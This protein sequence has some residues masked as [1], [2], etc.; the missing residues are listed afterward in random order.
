M[1]KIPLPEIKKIELELLDEL[2]EICERSELRYYLAFGTLIG[3]VRHQGFIPWDDDI[4][5]MMP[6]PDYEKLK[7]LLKDAE[8]KGK[9]RLLSNE[10]G[11]TKNNFM[12]MIHTGTLA[13]Q[14][15]VDE[16][17]GVWIDIFPIDGLPDSVF[18]TRLL[19]AK[20]ETYRR[21]LYMLIF[22]P[23][24]KN[25]LKNCLKKVAR[26]LLNKISADTLCRKVNSVFARYDYDSCRYAGAVSSVFSYKAR[27]PREVYAQGE[28]TFE[29]RRF[30]VPA[31]YDL[32]LRGIYGDYM[33][34]PPED[35]R[36]CHGFKAYWKEQA[37]SY[38]ENGIERR[39]LGCEKY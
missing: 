19:C 18:L 2:A 39:G 30:R 13:Y 35:K 28:A 37:D 24:G 4:D 16:K 20:L 32:L 3:A 5:V 6:R 33:E 29:G 22:V 17:I 23:A 25:R 7:H 9:Y 8:W 21:L 11:G 34:L 31:G 26:K 12:K 10:Y 36:E 14:K 1:R 27:V 15:N 38:T